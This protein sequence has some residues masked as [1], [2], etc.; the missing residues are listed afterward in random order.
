MKVHFLSAECYPAAKTGGLA[1]VVGA[2]PKYLNGLG[3]EVSVFMPKYHM[4]W[5]FEQNYVSEYVGNFDLGGEYITY[6][7][8]RLDKDVL[9]FY[10]YVIDIPGKFDR[11]GVYADAST[12]IFFG[13]EVERNISFQ[14]AYLEFINTW[15]ELPDIVHNHDHHTGLVPFMM[16]NCPQYSKLNKVPTVFTIHNQA[17]QGAFEWNRQYLLPRYD[18]WKSGMMDWQGRINPLASSVKCAWKVTTVSPSYMEE[19]K[20]RSFGLEWLFNAENFK[21]VGILNGIDTVVWDPKKDTYLDTH[22]KKDLHAFK[23]HYKA[24]II[25]NT[26]LDISQPLMCFIGRFAG[27]KGADILP[28]IIEQSILNGQHYNFIILGTGDKQ[29]EAQI[30][31]LATRYPNRIIAHIAYNEGLSRKIYAGSDFLIM[32]SRVEPCGLNQ[33][34]ALRYGTIPIVHD[35][36]GLRDSVIDF[37]GKD[38]CGF[39]FKNLN[40]GEILHA[41]HRAKECYYNQ[42]QFKSIRANALKM[43]YSWENSANQYLAIYKSLKKD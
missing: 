32:P 9:G 33:M 21:S 16:I 25:K 40:L 2:L 3:C 34:Y 24:E 11:N 15:T 35:L 22:M 8:E 31:S 18:S 26:S 29:V 13:D 36:G 42:S 37:D 5:F 28:G 12:G 39:K 4:Q 19:L 6:H 20:V 38:G 41:T 30:R 14:R 1:D 27:E 43:D 23:A 17:Y 7:V 10:L